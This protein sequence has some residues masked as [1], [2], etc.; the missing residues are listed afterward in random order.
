MVLKRESY[1]K[2]LWQH[3]VLIGMLTKREVVGRYKGSFFG[4][5]WSFLQPLLMLAVYTFV[6]GVIFN[7]RWPEAQVSSS[8][9][10]AI[11]FAGILIF[12]F[13]AECINRAPT[14]IQSNINFV[15]KVVFPLEII[16]CVSMTSALVHA[17]ISIII[18]VVF[19]LAVN[20]RL[21]WI[22]LSLPLILLPLMIFILGM[23]WFLAAIGVFYRDVGQIVG[24]ITSSMMFVCPIFYPITAIPEKYRFLI[25]MNPLTFFVENSRSVLVFGRTPDWNSLLFWYVI[26]IFVAW[27]GKFVFR[28]LR[29]GF[30]DVI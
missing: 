14:L 4:L 13:F 22:S 25:E 3:R 23:S 20:G 29:H 1:V 27:T 19:L 24:V 7:S 18:L 8:S 21:F 5:F 2:S 15:K 28:R 10:P 26:S 17:I 16:P 11:L 12:N 6:F 9:F 30:A